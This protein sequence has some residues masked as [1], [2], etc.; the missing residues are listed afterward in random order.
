MN[1]ILY[2]KANTILTLELWFVYILEPQ[3]PNFF[4]EAATVKMEKRLTY[5]HS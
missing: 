4:R 2:F 5:A 1:Y 3:K